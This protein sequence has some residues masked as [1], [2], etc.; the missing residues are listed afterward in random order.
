MLTTLLILLLMLVLL[1]I[2]G[3]FS[4]SEIAF[5]SADRVGLRAR[6][7]Q[8]DSGARQAL[9][10]LSDPARM[11][12]TTLLGTNIS[13]IT[14]TTV[15]TLLMVSLFGGHGELV[16]LLLFTPLFLILGEIV[17]KSVYQQKSDDL[18]PRIAHPL[19]WVQLA[20]SPLVWVF[21]GIARLAA[22]LIGGAKDARAATREQF[23]A[24]VQIAEK[25]GA[26]AAFGHGHVRRVLRFAQM[27]AAEAM[28]PLS[29]VACLSRDAE[30]RE[31]VHLRRTNEQRLIPL[32]DER[33]TNITAVAC[34]ESWDLLD[35]EIEK[36][37]VE[38]FHC[39]VKF[40]PQIQRVSEIIEMLHETPE[41]SVVVVNE[42]GDA[43]GL[44]TLNLLVRRTLGAQTNPITDRSTHDSGRQ[45]SMRDD[46][47]YRIDARTPIAKV[48]ERLGT[49]LSTLGQHTM[50]GLALAHFGR[51]PNC[52]ESFD[53]EGHRFTVVE[54]DE[55]RILALSA[56]PLTG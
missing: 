53:A 38:S 33:P 35:P 49:T 32:F 23:L 50:G 6:A 7:A 16:A 27:T 47:S 4:G 30:M 15:G 11:L 29:R 40:V 51:L 44:I 36:R 43:V 17:P 31:L 21:A 5:V 48:N 1:L 39:R 26:I 34:V 3:F 10:L 22:N 24:T 8:G 37:A 46:G 52:G 19:G 56:E 25:T 2:K 55:R 18:V 12:T 13:S 41:L 42:L 9:K 20:L 28:W 54:A 45:I 14:L